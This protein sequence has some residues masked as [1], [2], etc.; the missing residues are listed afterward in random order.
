MGTALAEMTMPQ[1]SP[2]AGEPIERVMQRR[3]V[4]SLGKRFVSV[5]SQA[6]Y[7]ARPCG[8]VVGSASGIAPQNRASLIRQAAWERAVNPDVAVLDE[9]LHL[10]ISQSAWRRGI[11]HSCF[12]KTAEPSR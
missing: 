9:V 8:G 11:G 1:I 2:V 6:D 3:C 12:P 4:G 10:V 5:D 7:G